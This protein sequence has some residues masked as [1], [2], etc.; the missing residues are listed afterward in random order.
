MAARSFRLL[1]SSCGPDSF[2]TA[3]AA[4]LL[5]RSEQLVPPVWRKL[6]ARTCELIANTAR[7]PDVVVPAADAELVK[8]QRKVAEY[9]W[10]QPLMRGWQPGEDAP[11]EDLLATLTAANPAYEIVT[12]AKRVCNDC[13]GEECEPKPD[14]LHWVELA[15]DDMVLGPK[16]NLIAPDSSVFDMGTALKSCAV[17]GGSRFIDR[18]CPECH[19]QQGR[20]KRSRIM[21]AARLPAWLAVNLR[22]AGS[23]SSCHA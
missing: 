16:G 12:R 7:R 11:L 23:E 5:A 13:R 4:V 17:L 19:K 10:G 9:L 15:A 8:V 6:A 3:A 18:A 14:S 21:T 20:G 2:T 22:H 1:N